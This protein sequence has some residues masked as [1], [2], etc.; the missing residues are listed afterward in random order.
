MQIDQYAVDF[1]PK[2]FMLMCLSLPRV[3]IQCL[4]LQILPIFFFITLVTYIQCYIC[5]IFKVLHMLYYV[6]S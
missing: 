3:D 6:A 1:P 4:P 5:K 2:T